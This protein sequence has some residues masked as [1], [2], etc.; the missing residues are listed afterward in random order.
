M[1]KKCVSVRIATS[2]H[3]KEARCCWGVTNTLNM[4]ACCLIFRKRFRKES[5]KNAIKSVERKRFDYTQYALFGGF[6]L[7]FSLIFH[8]NAFLDF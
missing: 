5:D 7:I 2:R 6:F 4:M 1:I 3:K 8:P